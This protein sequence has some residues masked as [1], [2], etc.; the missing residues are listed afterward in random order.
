MTG[1]HQERRSSLIIMQKCLVLA[2]AV[3]VTLNPT[4]VNNPQQGLNNSVEPNQT[5]FESQHA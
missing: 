1:T 5:Q 3:I 2:S 4:W